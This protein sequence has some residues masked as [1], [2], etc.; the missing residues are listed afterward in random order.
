MAKWEYMVIERRVKADEDKTRVWGDNPGLKMGQRERLNALGQDGWQVVG[1]Q[2]TSQAFVYILMRQATPKAE[3][4][5]TMATGRL[6]EWVAGKIS[7]K[8]LTKKE[9]GDLKQILELLNARERDI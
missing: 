8:E 2:A 3:Q 4:S 6:E 9:Q 1:F 7:S 5:V